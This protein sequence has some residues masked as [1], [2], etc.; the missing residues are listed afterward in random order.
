MKK[1][2][3][4]TLLIIGL[5]ASAMSAA[6]YAQTA[7]VTIGYP[8]NPQDLGITAGSYWIGQF[9][10]TITSGGTTQTDEAY[11]LNQEGTVYEGSPYTAT[12][13]PAPNTPA[14]QAV[15]YLLSWYSPTDNNGAAIDQVAIWQLLGT[16][17][18]SEFSLPQSVTDGAANLVHLSTTYS[19]V[20]P[21]DTLTWVSPIPG[22]TFTTSANTGQPV[23]L[24][25]QLKDS[26]GNPVPNVRVDFSAT[27][28]TPSLQK[29]Q[30]DS[31][32]LNP[33]TAFTDSSGIAQAVVTVPATALPGSTIQVQA[34]TQRVWPNL[35]LCLTQSQPGTQDLI[36]ANSGDAFGLTLKSQIDISG[37]ILV[38]PESAYGA[39]SAMVAFAASFIIYMKLK[40]S[41]S[42][43]L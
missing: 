30:L 8:S 6:A 36:V 16:Y 12:I 34:S 29:T 14:W 9:P 25:V 23:I 39:L 20:Q 33:M 27:L 38:L 40:H 35:Y 15:S 11:C 13:S 5:I 3:V 21:G 24:Q 22:S 41:K 2:I 1:R 32:Y 42:P 4:L 31:T 37:T 28:T 43:E 10:V 7:S 17:N 26:A 19:V 18:P